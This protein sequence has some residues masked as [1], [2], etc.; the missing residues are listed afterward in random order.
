MNAAAGPTDSAAPQDRLIHRIG[1]LIAGDAA[2][3]ALDWESH[4][5]IAAFEGDALRLSGFAYLHTDDYVA[6]TPHDPQLPRAF[7]DLREA[8]RK[9]GAPGWHACVVRIVRATRRIA[10]EFEYDDPA[11][12]A[13][14]PANLARIV[15]RAKP[16]TG[17]A[18]GNDAA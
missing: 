14:T 16:A 17:P 6:A 9:A 11:R 18:K 3:A 1:G 7:L 4:A 10:V 12:W 2:L 13:I 8:M 5:L 15:R